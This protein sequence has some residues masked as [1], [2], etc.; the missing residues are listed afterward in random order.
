VAVRAARAVAGAGECEG[1]REGRD[2]REQRDDDEV[3][4]LGTGHVRML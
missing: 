4:P 1:R 3:P 2:E